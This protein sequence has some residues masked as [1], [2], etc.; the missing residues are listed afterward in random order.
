MNDSTGI[1]LALDSPYE[2]RLAKQLDPFLLELALLL[3]ASET[4][5]RP[6]GIDPRPEGLVLG[7]SFGDQ[8]VLVLGLVFEKLVV[9]VVPGAALA[10]PYEAHLAKQL[11]PFLGEVALLPLASETVLHPLVG[12]PLPEGLVLGVVLGDQAVLVLGLVFEKLAVAVV[13]GSQLILPHFGFVAVVPGAAIDSP[14][15]ARLAKQLDPFLGELA[16]LPLASETVLIPLVANPRREGLVLRVSF[17]DQAVLVLGLVFEKLAVAVVPGAA[18]DSP[19]E[20][21][22]AKHLDPFLGEVALLPLASETVLHPLVGNP[23]PEGLVLGI[24]GWD[25]AVLVL[26]LVFEKLAVAVVPGAALVA[27]YEAHLAKQLDPFLGEVALLLLASETVLHPL[28]GN[29]LPEGLV[30]GIYGWDQAVLVL[31]LVFEKLVVA[32]VPGVAIDSLPLHLRARVERER[33]QGR[34]VGPLELRPSLLRFPFPLH[35]I[36]LF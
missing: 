23:L 20:A 26:V 19:Y 33:V 7:V 16:L 9:A 1:F 6:L 31:V 21:H 24:Y 14:Y 35:P 17:G 30:L 11:D 13:P 8:A 27:P 36:L 34:S 32:V 10:A 25:L 5:L 15:E 12:N 2:A 28:V 22:L 4:V 18:I 3:L 29:P